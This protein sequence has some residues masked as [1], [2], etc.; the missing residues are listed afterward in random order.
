M[1]FIKKLWI[2]SISY[3]KLNELE[4]KKKLREYTNFL[5]YESIYKKI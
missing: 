5:N 2:K 3:I 4:F 1:Y